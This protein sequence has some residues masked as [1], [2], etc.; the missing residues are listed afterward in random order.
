DEKQQPFIYIN[1]LTPYGN[2]MLMMSKMK[3]TRISARTNII[4]D[5]GKGLYSLA[6]KDSTGISIMVWNYQGTQSEGFDTDL[7]VDNLPAKWKNRLIHVSRYSIDGETSNY[8]A[9]LENCNLQMVEEKNVETDTFYHD[10]L[11][12]EPNSLQLII[13]KVA[14]NNR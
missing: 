1:K 9:D 4:I 11:H 14:D 12:L 10:Q 5:K 13:L 2:M 6:T 8:H 7:K 3:D